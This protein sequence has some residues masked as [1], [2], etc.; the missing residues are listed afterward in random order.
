MPFLDFI[1]II[2]L[3]YTMN[4]ACTRMYVNVCA[5]FVRFIYSFIEY[6][7]IYLCSCIE[8]NITYLYSCIEYNINL[9]GNCN[10]CKNADCKLF[11]NAVRL[12]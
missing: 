4:T 12:A 11:L 10:N 8:C 1:D 2:C 9:S 7:I 6:N 5:H 3:Y